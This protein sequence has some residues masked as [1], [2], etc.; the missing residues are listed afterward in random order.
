MKNKHNNF[1]KSLRNN[2][3]FFGLE[4]GLLPSETWGD[5]KPKEISFSDIFSKYQGQVIEI[6]GILK[7]VH[8][9]E[10]ISENRST[11]PKCGRHKEFSIIVSDKKPSSAWSD[12]ME[13]RVICQHCSKIKDYYNMAR[14]IVS[15]N[16]DKNILIELEE[17][18]FAYSVQLLEFTSSESER[19]LN[20]VYLTTGKTFSK[21]DRGKEYKIRGKLEKSFEWFIK[22]DTME[23]IEPDD[24]ID[25]YFIN[26][27]RDIP[28]YDEWR[29][30]VLSRD[31]KCVVC[32]GDKNLH[33]HHL[34]GYK[35]NPGLR[36]CKENGI[37]V[38]EWCH[39]KYHSYYGVNDINP[40]DFIRFIG[41]FGV[42]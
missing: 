21:K 24:T 39:Q 35:E 19:M 18:K 9:P 20:V 6:Q 5:V 12:D 22:T 41:R 38:C 26:D 17:E 29:Q 25:G 37:T 14:R 16:S 42:R 34:F 10:D 33:A 40:V 2:M 4:W 13:R 30:H 36:T 31:K 15:L 27:E 28:G 23:L 8:T 32:G 11:C 1:I 7:T 3:G